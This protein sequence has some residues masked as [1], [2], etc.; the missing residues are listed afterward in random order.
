MP[1]Y[2]LYRYYGDKA[3]SEGATETTLCQSRSCCDEG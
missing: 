3:C 2:I 1:P